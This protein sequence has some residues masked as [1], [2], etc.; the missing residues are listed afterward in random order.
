[1]LI[2][3]TAEALRREPDARRFWILAVLLG[4]REKAGR[5][6]VRFG[7]GDAVLYHRVEGR[8]WELAAV[9]DDLFPLL[10]PELRKVARLVAPERPE[11][12][13]TAGPPDATMESQQ[14]G[15]LTFDLGQRLIDLAV[16]IDPREPY[17]SIQLDIEYP[18]LGEL[19]GLAGEALDAYYEAD[20]AE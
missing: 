7:D 12:T 8:D 18:D 17:G 5:V 2:H 11:F 16:R 9:D 1:M 6:E 14:I 3:T 4:L 19:S 10:K 20:A 15:W 13:V